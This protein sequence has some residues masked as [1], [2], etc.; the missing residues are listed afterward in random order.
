MAAEQLER[1]AGSLKR[2]GKAWAWSQIGLQAA[3]R[4]LPEAIEWY[5]R[6]ATRAFRRGGGV[7]GARCAARAGL[8][9][10]A[11]DDRRMPPE[12]AAQPAWVYW[13]GRAYRAGGRLEEANALFAKIAG[14]PDFYGSLANDELGRP[15]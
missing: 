1:I 12:L 4:H 2:G 7:E 8:G 3:Q 5:R 6:P 11:L 10:R 13:L 15:P 9:Q 14:Q